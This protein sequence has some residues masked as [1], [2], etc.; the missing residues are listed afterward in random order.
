MLVNIH[1]KNMDSLQK[2]IDISK[3]KSNGFN[4]QKLIFL[5]VQKDNNFLKSK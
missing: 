4:N 1:W 2:V 3:E 5:Q